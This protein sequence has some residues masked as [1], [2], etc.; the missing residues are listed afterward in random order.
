MLALML[1]LFFPPVPVKP[2]VEAPKG[3]PPEIVTA[4]VVKGTLVG[5][6][7]ETVH[8]NVMR[9]VKEK[10]GGKEVVKRVFTVMPVTRMTERRWSLDKATITEAGG[11]KLDKEALTRRLA[12]PAV[13]LVS[14][15]GKTID[16]G[17]LK[18]LQKDTIVIVATPE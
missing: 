18:V 7:L 10:V 11:K 13:V 12:K 16:P 5:T 17:Y 15:D 3:L 9:E 6:R 2:E 1:A 14:A 4:R 8:V